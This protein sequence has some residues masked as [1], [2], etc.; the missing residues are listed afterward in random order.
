MFAEH[1]AALVSCAAEQ[2]A[3]EHS[4]A[5][6]GASKWHTEDSVA[7]DTPFAT[8]QAT[9]QQGPTLED[10]AIARRVRA[11]SGGVHLM[12]RIVDH[13]SDSASSVS[14]RVCVHL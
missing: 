3:T 5:A 11:Q 12:A 6:E 8:A 7:G 1:L 14:S 4:R 9:E 10:A 13:A 2:P